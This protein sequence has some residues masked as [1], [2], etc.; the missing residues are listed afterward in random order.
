[1][2]FPG[3]DGGAKFSLRV[4]FRSEAKIGCRK[5]RIF[6]VE[7]C[8]IPRFWASDSEFLSNRKAV[9]NYPLHE[10]RLFQVER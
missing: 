2:A 1:M 9:T 10:D 5:F 8:F 6:A 4:A 3:C 7:T